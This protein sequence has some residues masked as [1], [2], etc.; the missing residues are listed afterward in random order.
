M[1]CGEDLF[2]ARI[3]VVQPCIA[4]RNADCKTMSYNQDCANFTKILVDEL[5]LVTSERIT[6]AKSLLAEGKSYEKGCSGFVCDVLQI[7]REDAKSL[8]ES[9]AQYVGKDNS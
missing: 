7:T 5:V 1:K 4:V 9:D 8:I 6:R 2:G 3:V